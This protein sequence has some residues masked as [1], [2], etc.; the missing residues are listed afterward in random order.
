MATVVLPQSTQTTQQTI[1]TKHDPTQAYLNKLWMNFMGNLSFI[2]VVS[3]VFIPVCFTAFLF[4][5]YGFLHGVAFIAAVCAYNHIE[6]KYHPLGETKRRWESFINFIGM[7]YSH[8]PP[9]HRP[10]HRPPHCPPHR[11]PHRP[12][13]IR[14]L[15]LSSCPLILVHLLTILNVNRNI[16]GAICT[17][18][19]SECGQ[20]CNRFPLLS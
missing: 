9:P 20:A 16:V 8:R 5:Y 14:F 10:P 15:S 2:I 4:L 1:T 12:L 17:H 19:A 11:P 18:E 3:F 7:S 13:I 6:S